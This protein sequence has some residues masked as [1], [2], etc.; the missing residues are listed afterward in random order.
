M[1]EELAAQTAKDTYDYM[2][3]D[4]GKENVLNPDGCIPIL[5][6][7]F[8]NSKGFSEE[9][10][11]RVHLHVTKVMKSDEFIRK[12]TEIRDMTISFYINACRKL[13]EKFGNDT[14]NLMNIPEAAAGMTPESEIH[15][16]LFALPI[17]LVGFYSFPLTFVLAGIYIVFHFSI[18]KAKEE[19]IDNSYKKYATLV[20]DKI[21]KDSC[22][23]LH[24]IIDKIM[25][26]LLPR[27]IEAYEERIKQLQELH[28]KIC[29]EHTT[30]R[31]LAEKVT[32]MKT[33][34]NEMNISLNVQKTIALEN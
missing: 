19:I 5:K 20:R 18:T 17:M 6:V 11:S 2:L 22:D 1:K 12:Y 33:T 24:D 13:E 10:K 4:E 15:H 30:L 28:E 3:S 7:K 23:I 31:N 9:L 25:L 26:D 29:D 34:A 21:K 14:D 8:W 16:L 27:R 32:F